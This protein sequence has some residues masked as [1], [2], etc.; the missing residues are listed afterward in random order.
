MSNF[1]QKLHEAKKEAVRLAAKRGKPQRLI[2][3]FPSGQLRIAEAT[4]NFKGRSHGI[5][6]P[7]RGFEDSGMTIKQTEEE[8]SARRDV[9]TAIEMQERLRY[10]FEDDLTS[11]L[12]FWEGW[13]SNYA[14]E[15]AKLA[16]V[17]LYAEK[18]GE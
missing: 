5:A 1:A 17:E 4:P 6:Y 15:I 18:E 10:K 11:G 13:N 3:D 9:Q 7:M 8:E 12:E 2:E 16:W 14:R